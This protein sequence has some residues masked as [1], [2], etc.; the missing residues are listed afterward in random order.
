MSLMV[1]T[2]LLTAGFASIAVI[3]RAWTYNRAIIAELYGQVKR[4]EFGGDIIVTL[5]DKSED[6][7]SIFA[8]RR[9]R[10]LRIHVPKPVTHRL[11]HFAKTRTVA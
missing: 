3:W 10:P 8:L 2:L 7:D 9:A 4:S 1:S 11:H 6:L 5:R